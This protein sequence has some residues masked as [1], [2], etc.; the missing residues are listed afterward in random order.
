MCLKR[1]Q[2][3]GDGGRVLDEGADKDTRQQGR[4]L[5]FLA[6]VEAPAGLGL[7]ARAHHDSGGPAGGPELRLE[8]CEAPRVLELRVV[9]NDDVAA[10]EGGAGALPEG[11]K[12]DPVAISKWA[13][14]VHHADLP[15]GG[16]KLGRWD[17]FKW[18]G[19]MAITCPHH[20]SLIAIVSYW[21]VLCS[22]CSVE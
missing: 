8:L 22:P 20:L 10:G 1:R 7:H 18:N 19:G 14:C 4:T 13:E 9:D 3:A 16:T 15:P 21:K 5:V 2:A 11:P 12:R 17:N 6:P